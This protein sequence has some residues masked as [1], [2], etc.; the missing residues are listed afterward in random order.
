MSVQGQKIEIPLLKP[1][2]LFDKRR[3]KDTAK[4]KAYNKILEQ[5]Y[6]RVRTASRENSDPWI[7]FTIPPFIIG[8]PRIDLEDCVV[9]LVYMLRQQ[10]YEVRYTYPNLLY[11]SWK[12]HEKNYIL[13]DSPIMSVMLA[14]QNTKPKAEL[15]GQSQARVRFAD[16]AMASS[17]SQKTNQQAQQPVR[18]STA[19]RA[20]PRSVTDYQPPSSFLDAL[21]K[22]PVA[23][24]RK[25]A[26]DDF[27]NF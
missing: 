21:E 20:P 16:Q 4:L 13:K 10:T 17:G 25:S 27:M 14:A 3:Q 22:G 9:F 7:L 1:T 8:L 12:H 11:I 26:L 6:T 5:I 2:D 19:G 15:R 18:P 23:E 24:P